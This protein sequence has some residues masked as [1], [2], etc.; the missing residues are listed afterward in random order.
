MNQS[1]TNFENPFG[2][3]FIRTYAQSSDTVVSPTLPVDPNLTGPL[4]ESS[5]VL[6]ASASMVI[7]GSP[8]I[9]VG[10]SLTTNL[11]INSGGQ[12]ISIV[13]IVIEY[14][15]QYL[16]YTNHEIPSVIELD[17]TVNEPNGTITMVGQ[18]ESP[19]LIN[20]ILASID[21]TSIQQ[22]STTINIVPQ[23][24]ILETIEGNNVLENARGATVEILGS[25]AVVT[26][27]TEVIITQIPKSSLTDPGNIWGVL[28]GFLAIVTGFWA[29][30]TANNRRRN[31]HEY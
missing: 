25:D 27:P 6:E 22:G 16:R 26:S 15:G 4:F 7:D 28:I 21:F 20:Q 24:S 2:N 10:D 5:E 18:F 1:N 29:F 8:Q 31:P 17:V 19:V 14:D 30:V 9:R 12:S 11:E 13:S 3:I 23:M